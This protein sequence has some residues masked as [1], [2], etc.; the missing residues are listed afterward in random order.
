M[1]PK[2]VVVMKYRRY[3]RAF[4]DEACTLG[5]KLDCG[6][7]LAAERLGMPEATL[8]LWMKQQGLLAPKAP[9]VPDTDDPQALKA[10]IRQLQEQLRQSEIDKDI[11]KK[12]AAYFARE[13]P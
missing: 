4:K 12:A 3:T 9:G 10:Q 5:S 8:R 7:A 13:N 11:L 1:L 2:G 6:P